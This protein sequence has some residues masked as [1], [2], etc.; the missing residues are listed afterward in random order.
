[1]NHEELVTVM[2]WARGV[3]APVVP[4]TGGPR[5]LV[6]PETLRRLREVERVH[7]ESCGTNGDPNA[8]MVA[9]P[10]NCDDGLTLTML[11][12]VIAALG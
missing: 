8:W 9:T 5:N 10:A 4:E 2:D 6:S 11:R 3:G 12:E 7:G 1:M